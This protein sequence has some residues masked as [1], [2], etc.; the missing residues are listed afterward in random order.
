MDY[1]LNL[2]S[3]DKKIRFYCGDKIHTFEPIPTDLKHEFWWS[4]KSHKRA[5]NEMLCEVKVTSQLQNIT[6]KEAQKFLYGIESIK[7]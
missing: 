3:L 6:L 5:V 2:I 1:S 7:S 4:E